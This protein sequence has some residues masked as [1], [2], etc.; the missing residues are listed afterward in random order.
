MIA[1]VEAGANKCT[2][3]AEWHDIELDIPPIHLMQNMSPIKP[4]AKLKILGFVWGI[5]LYLKV[6]MLYNYKLIKHYNSHF[7]KR[8]SLCALNWCISNNVYPLIKMLTVEPLLRGHPDK[9]PPHRERPLDNVNLNINVLI[10]T[11]DPSW[12][13]IFLMQRGWP[14]KRFSTVFKRNSYIAHSQGN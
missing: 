6:K 5:H 3:S 1:S 2:T 13:A 14:H 8:F 7:F 4:S 11:S 10:S 9:R 12:K